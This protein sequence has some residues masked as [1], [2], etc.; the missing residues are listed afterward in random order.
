MNRRGFLGA[1]IATCAAPA[2][3]RADSLM[4]IVPR[5]TTI[6]FDT[7]TVMAHYRIGVMKLMNELLDNGAL[8]I[9]GTPR[10]LPR[11]TG[12]VIKFRRYLPYVARI[13]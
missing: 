11:N 4:R 6:V 12:D 8:V 3:V 13:Q 7:E 1:I 2:I 9:S 10:S 5:Y